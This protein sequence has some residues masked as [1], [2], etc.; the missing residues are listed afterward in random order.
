MEEKN[1]VQAKQV[2]DG[3]RSHIATSYH[4]AG[5]VEWYKNALSL[6]EILQEKE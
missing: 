6:Y 2:F 5:K 1:Y 4:T 3:H